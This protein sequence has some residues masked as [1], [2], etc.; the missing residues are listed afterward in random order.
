MFTFF[1]VCND[2][3]HLPHAMRQSIFIFHIL[4]ILAF[5]AI[6]SKSCKSVAQRKNK[7]TKRQKSI[8]VQ[9]FSIYN[10]CNGV[11]ECA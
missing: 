10:V 5:S 2:I 3:T 1:F 4:N 9:D 11:T 7:E 6:F 8:L